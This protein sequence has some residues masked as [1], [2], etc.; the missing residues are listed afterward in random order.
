MTKL[1]LLPAYIEA[2]WFCEAQVVTLTDGVGQAVFVP[3]RLEW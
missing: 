3:V 2:G 1:R